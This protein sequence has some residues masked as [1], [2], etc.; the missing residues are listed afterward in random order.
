MTTQPPW[1]K[2]NPYDNIPPGYD[3][4]LN[5]K[6]GEYYLAHKESPREDPPKEVPPWTQK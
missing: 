1:N 4:K 5:P 6:T 2:D 3:A